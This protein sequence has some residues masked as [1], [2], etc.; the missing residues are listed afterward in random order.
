MQ[1]ASYCKKCLN[2]EVYLCAFSVQTT[3]SIWIFQRFPPTEMDKFVCSVGGQF[4][5]VSANCAVQDQTALV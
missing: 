4:R 5:R 2:N 3:L 1:V